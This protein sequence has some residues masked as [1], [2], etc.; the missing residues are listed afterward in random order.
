MSDWVDRLHIKINQS[1]SIYTTFTLKMN[2]YLLFSV[3]ITLN[4]I[5]ISQCSRLIHSN[6]W[7]SISIN[8]QHGT[9][10]LYE[11]KDSQRLYSVYVY[12]VFLVSKNNNTNLKVKLLISKTSHSRFYFIWTYADL[13]EGTGNTGLCPGWHYFSSSH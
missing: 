3:F 11:L 5:L 10:M 8:N 6:I 1:K 2:V 13:A 9:T 12:S 7:D 4:I